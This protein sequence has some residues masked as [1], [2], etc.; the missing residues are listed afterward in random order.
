MVLNFIEKTGGTIVGGALNVIGIKHDMA[1]HCL[2]G[3]VPYSKA[4]NYKAQVY[5]PH[6]NQYVLKGK[7]PYKPGPPRY[8]NK[9]QFN[10]ATLTDTM[11]RDS[12][13]AEREWAQYIKLHKEKVKC[14]KGIGWHEDNTPIWVLRSKD[15]A[16]LGTKFT[17]GRYTFF[18]TED[19]DQASCQ[20][21]FFGVDSSQTRCCTG[22]QDN[23]NKKN[24]TNDGC[25]HAFGP[26]FNSAES[27]RDR[28][29]YLNDYWV[30]I[31]KFP[32]IDQSI[33]KF[34][35]IKDPENSGYFKGKFG[36][37]T[38]QTLVEYIPVGDWPHTRCPERCK[39]VM[40][41]NLAQG[42]NYMPMP[43]LK[44]GNKDGKKVYMQRRCEKFKKDNDY[45]LVLETPIT[46]DDEIK[47]Y[48]CDAVIDGA[49]ICPEQNTMEKCLSQTSA[50]DDGYVRR[51]CDWYPRCHDDRWVYNEEA[52]KRMPGCKW[53]QKKVYSMFGKEG[54]EM[55]CMTNEEEEK[56]KCKSIIDE[57]FGLGFKKT[58]GLEWQ[59][60]SWEIQSM[61]D[62]NSKNFLPSMLC[63]EK[64]G[65]E[66]PAGEKCDSRFSA[67]DAE[68]CKHCAWG[69]FR[70]DGW[71][72]DYCAP[73]PTQGG[74]SKKMSKLT[75]FMGKNG[76]LR[77]KPTRPPRP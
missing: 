44:T 12:I 58:F 13:I 8:T 36:N 9:N 31:D 55:R 28:S 45:C 69:F 2:H 30:P 46:R 74:R 67:T 37:D 64:K 48:Q 11:C 57:E 29:F 49:N 63:G 6:R 27:L 34:K 47:M 54:I 7:D 16:F 21:C 62:E 22:V 56:G 26:F 61:C 3:S 71:L 32:S 68:Q 50:D 10:C 76:C 25:I 1:Y 73:A 72:N 59:R 23:D 41:S 4:N 40:T 65:R 20:R 43:P 15:E 19:K 75:Y 14:D 52:C 18:N 77:S 42:I 38:E 60:P 5:P 35:N 39:N 33:T 70:E 17:G 53:G 66:K 24:T 51:I